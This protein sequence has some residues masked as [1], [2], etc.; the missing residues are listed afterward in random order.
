MMFMKKLIPV[1]KFHVPEEELAKYKDPTCFLCKRR[2]SEISKVVN[3]RTFKALGGINVLKIGSKTQIVCD[4][5]LTQLYS[6][7]LQHLFLRFIQLHAEMCS[8]AGLQC[9]SILICVKM[10]YLFFL[11][12]L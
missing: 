9:E 1:F 7:K 2:R 11:I 4:D 3:F 10:F 5:C 12:L 6:S 8:L